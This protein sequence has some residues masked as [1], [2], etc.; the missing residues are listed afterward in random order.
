MKRIS[1]AVITL[2]AALTACTKDIQ[3]RPLTIE[4]QTLMTK[5]VGGSMEESEPGSLLIKVNGSLA[6]ELSSNR[7]A[8]DIFTAEENITISP[9]LPIRPK[10]MEAAR[11][12]GLDR[13]FVLRF[14]ATR[15]VEEMARKIALNPSVTAV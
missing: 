13:W 4:E 8:I 11:R 1:F 14:D 6:E 15:P 10:N 2:A 5:L 9:A 7:S 3:E 12:Y